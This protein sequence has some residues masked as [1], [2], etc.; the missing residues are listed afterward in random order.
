MLAHN[1]YNNT[2]DRKQ[3]MVDNKA[4]DLQ[5]LVIA[6]VSLVLF[7]IFLCAILS[8]GSFLSQVPLL[9]TALENALS[10]DTA[11]FWAIITL[12][13]G[14]IVLTIVGIVLLAALL[15]EQRRREAALF[16]FAAAVG[17]AL[18]VSIKA[19]VARGRPDGSELAGALYSFPSGHALMATII[20]G[21]IILFFLATPRRRLAAVA[22]AA[23]ILLVGAS[24]VMLHRHYL[25]DVITGFLLGVAVLAGT[26]FLS[27]LWPLVRRKIATKQA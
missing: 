13:G 25:S 16:A 15:H 22:I 24:R 4:P 7:V 3:T 21:S 2:K 18:D 5:P 10:H 11:P 14:P 20:Y 19:M 6:C 17:L 1:K 12:F 8:N 27:K 9:D 26:I 23:L